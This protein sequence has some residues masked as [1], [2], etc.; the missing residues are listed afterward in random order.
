M[1]FSAYK[2]SKKKYKN[3]KNDDA[4][5][6]IINNI[7][8]S[9]NDDD[10]ALN[11]DDPCIPKNNACEMLQYMGK[12]IGKGAES[13]V[14]AYALDDTLCIKLLRILKVN[15]VASAWGKPNS[16]LQLGKGLSEH[17]FYELKVNP[18]IKLCKLGIAPM[19]HSASICTN[20]N[21][22]YGVI[23]MDRIYGYTLYEIGLRRKNDLDAAK[24]YKEVE[25]VNNKGNKINIYLTPYEYN[26]YK[27]YEDILMAEQIITFGISDFHLGNIMYD[28]RKDRYYVVDW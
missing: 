27:E 18:L 1:Y 21:I 11:N 19:I 8:E 14:H 23:V 10:V 28:V 5:D 24:M 2:E 25:S 6:S 3:L 17:N 26:I 15:P 12:L 16:P 4:N 7:I 9:K 20:N 13:T 22:K